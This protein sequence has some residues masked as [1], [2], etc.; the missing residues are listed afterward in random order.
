VLQ[1]HLGLDHEAVAEVLG[2]PTGTV[3]SRAYSARQ[4]LRGFIEADARQAGIRERSA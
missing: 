1:H 3:K 2:I 4:A